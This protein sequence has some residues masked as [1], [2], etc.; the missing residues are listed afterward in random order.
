[1]LASRRETAHL[2]PS[3]DIFMQDD[4]TP[5]FVAAQN[6]HLEVVKHLSERAD[7][8]KGRQVCLGCP[9]THIIHMHTRTPVA[10]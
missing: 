5:L 3:H 8:D 10:S 7:K 1:M 9:Y 2:Q 6:G 4:S